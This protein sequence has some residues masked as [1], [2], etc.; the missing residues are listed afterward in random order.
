L[1]ALQ[2]ARRRQ[3]RSSEARDRFA[4]GV[5]DGAR[6]EHQPGAVSGAADCLGASAQGVAL[7][8]AGREAHRGRGGRTPF[9]AD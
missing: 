3:G 2:P 4:G 9:G 7:D 5:V 8:G 1:P 6:P